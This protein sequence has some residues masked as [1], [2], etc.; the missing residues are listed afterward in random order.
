MDHISQYT[1][2]NILGDAVRK[3]IIIS[4]IIG[5]VLGA[6]SV[7]LW[8]ATVAMNKKIREQPSPSAEQQTAVAQTPIQKQETGTLIQNDAIVVPNQKAGL[9][10]AISYVVF[11]SDGWVVIHEG[12]ESQIGNALGA[13]RFDAG[14]HSGVVELLRPTEAGKI[15]RAVLY[16]D[17]GDRE[18]SLDSDF[19]FLQKGN[20]PVITVF[21][22]L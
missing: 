21:R 12:T 14:E 6:F 10:V 7:W 5:F 8:V 2:M 22:A 19:P 9:Q 13:T 11:E 16:H 18:F 15:Y 17:N 4:F 3:R 20:E 1:S